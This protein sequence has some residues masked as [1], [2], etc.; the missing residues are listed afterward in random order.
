M[1]T[2]KTNNRVLKFRELST[3][4]VLRVACF[5][6]TP[7]LKCEFFSIHVWRSGHVPI[8]GTSSPK[9]RGNSVL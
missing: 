8:F 1:H 9:W 5:L 2:K 7:A 4:F 3:E 6:T